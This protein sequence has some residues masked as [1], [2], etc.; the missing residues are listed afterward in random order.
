MS[1]LLALFA[2]CIASILVAWGFRMLGAPCHRFIPGLLIGVLLGP[3]VLGRI[4]PD[5]W[6]GIFAG[7]AEARTHLQSLDRAHASWHFAAE[8]TGVDIE[9]KMEED[10]RHHQRREPLLRAEVQARQ[11][12]Q[13]PWAILT[14]ILAFSA[15]L[16]SIGSSAR[17]RRLSGIPL[18]GGS[19]IG[20]WSAVVPI[21][22]VLLM[23]KGLGFNPFNAEVLLLAAAVAVGPWSLGPNE[24]RIV[25]RMQGCQGAWPTVAAHVAT[26]FAIALAI[27]AS[28]HSPLGWIVVALAC[29]GLLRTT[30]KRHHRRSLRSVRDRFILPSLAA[31]AVLLSDVML[32]ARFWPILGVAVLCSDGRWLGAAIGLMLRGGPAKNAA[33]R[34]AIVAIDASGPQL[35][36][37]ALATALGL[38]SGA[39]TTSLLFGVMLIELT[40]PLRIT[41][42]RQLR[43]ATT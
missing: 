23:A 14:S 12:H 27:I 13:K 22:G 25:G 17:I 2:I 10:H 37:T 16:L 18:S 11:S 41:L 28:I 24:H 4:A 31:M 38:I 42:E 9:T 7:G 19:S 39:W 21:L 32:D 29:L 6:E 43:G 8:A 20:A 26:G 34:G 40:S 1:L 33:M 35:A 36:I 15:A 3:A 5:A 30:T